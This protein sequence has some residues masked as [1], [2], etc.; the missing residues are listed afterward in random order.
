MSIDDLIFRLLSEKL[1]K[2]VKRVN[3]MIVNK[4][5]IEKL[6]LGYSEDLKFSSNRSVVKANN[7]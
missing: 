5:N 4:L 6:S 2:I 1:M 7:E 3:S